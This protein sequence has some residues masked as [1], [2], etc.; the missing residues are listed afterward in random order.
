M[1]KRKG[2]TNG[3]TTRNQSS[4]AASGNAPEIDTAGTPPSADSTAVDTASLVDGSDGVDG[5]ADGKG[6]TDAHAASTTT[7]EAVQQP[8]GVGLGDAAALSGGGEG[9][10]SAGGVKAAGGSDADGDGADGDHAGGPSDD[11]SIGTAAGSTATDKPGNG[12][13][14]GDDGH[15]NGDGGLP[16]GAGPGDDSDG[17]QDKA[18]SAGSEISPDL[19]AALELAGCDTAENLIDMARIGSNVMEAIDDVR[20]LEGP[21]KDWAPMD[22]PA[23]IIHDLYNALEHAREKAGTPASDPEVH[24]CPIC[25]VPFKAD[26]VCATDIDEGTCHA[27]CL[28][29]SPVVDL[30]TGEPKAGPVDTFLYSDPVGSETASRPNSQPWWLTA[31]NFSKDIDPREISHSFAYDVFRG[32]HGSVETAGV[33]INGGSAA[34]VP[35]ISFEAVSELVELVRRI[36]PRATPDVLAQHLVIT[37]HRQSAELTKAEELGLKAFAS[38]LIDLDEYATAEKKR[39]EDLAAEKPKPRPVPIDE[40]NMELVDGPMATH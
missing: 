33:V 7:T 19:K 39:L 21:F 40:T 37:K 27:E 4:P 38:I 36:G 9:S 3:S 26:D 11:G 34:E 23:E 32:V 20:K 2:Q 13:K 8:E 30:D 25:D 17:S 24:C 35:S 12:G 28:A 22:D 6:L 16:P 18:G 14:L 10:A 31:P 1:S 29:G 15:G 5:A